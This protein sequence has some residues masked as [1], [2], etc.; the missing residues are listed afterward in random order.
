[1]CLKGVVAG[2]IKP[3]SCSTLPEYSLQNFPLQKSCHYLPDQPGT[4]SIPKWSVT[5]PGW[6]PPTFLPMCLGQW[7]PLVAARRN[8]GPEAFSVADLV[9]SSVRARMV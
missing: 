5:S 1:M 6:C 2:H 7:P 3:G 8:A 4:I 9:A